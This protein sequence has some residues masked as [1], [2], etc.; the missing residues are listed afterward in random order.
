MPV[1]RSRLPSDSSTS[2]VSA[3]KRHL[4]AISRASPRSEVARPYS[5]RIVAMRAR[6]R[7]AA[8]SSGPARGFSGL[9]R[10]RKH[11]DA[12][13]KSPVTACGRPRLWAIIRMR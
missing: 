5:P 11:S 13:R 2:A 7:Y 4:L 1:S 12:L 3:C 10:I 6:F 9:V 8:P